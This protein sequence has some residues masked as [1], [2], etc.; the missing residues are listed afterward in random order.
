VCFDVHLTKKQVQHGN[1]EWSSA[2]TTAAATPTPVSH[3]SGPTPFNIDS[4]PRSWPNGE[5]R[6][7]TAALEPDAYGISAA[8]TTAATGDYGCFSSGQP[9]RIE[10]IVV[11]D[12]SG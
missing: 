12:G 4:S 8:A 7:P 6:S 5:Q 2:A 11:S 10:S 9:T 1:V 3:R